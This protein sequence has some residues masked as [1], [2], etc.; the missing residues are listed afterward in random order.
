MLPLLHQSLLF[1][2]VILGSFHPAAAVLKENAGRHPL[3]LSSTELNYDVK[4]AAMQISCRIFTDDFEELIGKKYKVKSDLSSAAKHKEMDA[5]INKYMTAHIGLAANGKAIRLNYLGFEN[6]NEAVVVFLESE[7][8]KGIKK[9][10]TTSTVLYDLFDDQINI[11]HLTSSGSRKSF[12]LTYPEKI[13][14]S[15]F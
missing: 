12:K 5:L 15:V 13:M 8:V 1:C 2:Y 9:L 6:D 3:H 7:K 14:V 10:E 11:F 4:T